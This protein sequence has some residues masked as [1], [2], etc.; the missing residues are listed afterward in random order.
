LR[1]LVKPTSGKDAAAPTRSGDSPDAP[2][3]AEEALQQRVKALEDERDR[4]KTELADFRDRYLRTRAD[5]DNLVR[6]SQKEALDSVRAAKGSLLLRLTAV[7]ESF[8]RALKDLERTS[9]ESAKG[10]RL[11]ADELRRL[12]KDEG[13]KEIETAGAFNYR[14]H[15]A[16]ESVETTEHPEGTIL[17]VVQRGY[18]IHGE[19]LRHALVRVATPPRK[20]PSRPESA[21]ST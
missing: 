18:L 17:E 5:Y 1:N 7:V 16:V 21:A 19:V 13:V 11:V 15:Q 12:L 10:V 2:T 3:K 20:A 14:Y 9:P 6:R 4:L 8:D